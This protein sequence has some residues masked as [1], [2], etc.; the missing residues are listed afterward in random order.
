MEPLAGVVLSAIVPVAG[1]LEQMLETFRSQDLAPALGA[2]EAKVPQNAANL[3]SKNS[4]K[5][6]KGYVRNIYLPEQRFRRN[7]P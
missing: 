7:R 5:T 1:D 2:V 3:K 6:G 4:L